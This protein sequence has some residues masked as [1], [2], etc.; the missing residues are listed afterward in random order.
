MKLTINQDGVKREIEGVF[1]FCLTPQDA[2]RI[3]DILSEHKSYGWVTIHDR[4]TTKSEP[5]TKALPWKE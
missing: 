1:E 3:I 4:V 2:Q 5:N